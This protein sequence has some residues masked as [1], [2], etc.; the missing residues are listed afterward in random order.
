MEKQRIKIDFEPNDAQQPFFTSETKFILA[1]GGV[2]SGKS[3]LVSIKGIKNSLK[4]GKTLGLIGRKTYP[5]LRDTTRRTFFEWVNKMGLRPFIKKWNQTE[6]HLT[7]MNGSEI[8]FRALDDIYKLGS[9]ELG[10]FLIDELSEF[11]DPDVFAFLR[12]RLRHPSGPLT[13]GGATNPAT[14]EHWLYK[15]FVSEQHPDYQVVEV[16]TFANKENL[17][18]EY[19]EDL[20]KLPEEWQDRYLLGKWGI[21]PK[22]TRVFSKFRPSIHLGAYKFNPHSYVMRGW[23][24][25]FRHPACVFAQETD[26]GRL[27]IFKEILG[28]EIQIDDFADH[29]IKKSNEWYPNTEFVDYCDIAGI[30]RSDKTGY[31]SVQMLRKR[32]LDPR[33]R[34]TVDKEKELMFINNMF[35]QL[36]GDLPRIGVDRQGCPILSDALAGG[37]Y[38][39]KNG[40]ATGDDYF[41]HLCD[42]LRYIIVNV[43]GTGER[44]RV[45]LQAGVETYKTLSQARY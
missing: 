8:L 45:P 28:T 31:T 1:N 7:W 4:Y 12:T 9:L 5:E 41:D 11:D 25:G 38:R 43:Y 33:Y 15:L 32:D 16:P 14:K 30:H 10:W 19:L 6:N 21:V 29:V 17:P 20:S 37:Y 3:T 42:A 27:L 23:D 22:G 2:G 34:K 24:F 18:K 39:D 40:E 44:M 35:E 26:W 36:R 13:G